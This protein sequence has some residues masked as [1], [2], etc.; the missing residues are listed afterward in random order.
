[1]TIKLSGARCMSLTR[2]ADLQTSLSRLDRSRLDYVPAVVD[3]ILDA[4]HRRQA[5]DIHFDPT[6]RGLDV[7]F[8]LDGVLHAAAQLPLVAAPNVIA[9]LKVL[10]ELLT[11]RTD[12]PQE[13]RLHWPAAPAGGEMRLS[14]F[15]TIHGE[16][17]AVRLFDPSG[18][19]LELNQLGLDAEVHRRLLSMLE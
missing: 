9:R 11:Y 13:G 12:I 4:A 17:A 18:Q 16:K 6:L 1:M 10:A 2:S 14:T 3:R 5:S 19:I 15:P 8:R 7:R